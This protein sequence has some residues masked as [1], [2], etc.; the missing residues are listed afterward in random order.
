MHNLAYPYEEQQLNIDGTLSIIPVLT[1]ENKFRGPLPFYTL[2][3]PNKL[4]LV[5]AYG[6]DNIGM[7]VDGD[8]ITINDLELKNCDFGNSLANLE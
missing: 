5:T 6:Q 1:S 8:N 2:G 4:P 7:Y 3:D